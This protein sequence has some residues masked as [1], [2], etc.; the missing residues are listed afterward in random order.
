MRPRIPAS[1]PEHARILIIGDFPGA[2]DEIKGQIFQGTAGHELGKMLH[3]AGILRYDCRLTNIL[4]ARPSAG[5]LDEIFDFKKKKPIGTTIPLAIDELMKEIEQCN[6]NIII[7]LGGLALYA[8]NGDSAISTWRGS[9]LSL[10]GRKCIPTY[11]PSQIQRNWE[12]RAIAVADLRRAARE[13]SS[14]DFTPIVQNFIVRP[15]ASVVLTQLSSLLTRVQAQP[16]L[17]S[18]DI[19][20]RAGHTACTGIAWSK[21]DAICIPHMCVE[22]NDGFYDF[23]EEVAIILALRELLTHPNARVVGQNFLYDAQYFAKHWGFIPRLTEDTMFMQNMLFPGMPKGLDFL[24]SM[25]CENYTY[26][27]GEGKLW[28]P[29]LPEDQLWVYNCK[30][31]VNT[32]EIAE[33]C[34]PM[35]EQQNKTEQYRFQMALWWDVLDMMLRGVRIDLKYRQ[36]LSGEL[37]HEISKREEWLKSVCSHAL[38]PRSPKQMQA[39]FYADLRLPVQ[40]Q[41]KGTRSVTTDDEALE[42]LSVLEPL[43]A[44]ICNC[45]RELRS[46][47][48]FHSTF[49]LAGLGEDLRMRCSFN[50]AGT[51]TYRFNSSKD[52]FDSGTNLQNIPKGNEDEAHVATQLVL[53]NIRKLFIPDSEHIIFDVDLAG[54]DAQVVAWEANDDIL[55]SIFRS[56]QKVHAVNAKDIFGGNAGDDGKREPYYSR[57]K[58][59]CHLTNYGGK[60]RTLSIALGITI[61]E[62]ELFQRRWF[63][64]HPGIA[65]WHERVLSSLQTTRSISNK[66][67]YSRF[68]FDRIDGILPQALAWIPQSTVACVTNRQLHA[69]A[70]H[71]P[72]AQILLQVHDSLVG[73][74]HRSK[75]FLT[76]P[77]LR[78]RLRITVPYEDPL[79]IPSGLKT[80]QVSWGAAIDESWD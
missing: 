49:V 5:S 36:Q 46:L 55:K 73:Q 39:F 19:E 22:R 3:E 32:Y 9:L 11:H 58:A 14:P 16:T 68:Y 30:D 79:I 80:S 65:D 74:V 29:R 67:G 20:T 64:I 75:W 35:I 37:M 18:V 8:I 44:P 15:S 2:D 69:V 54:A 4:K 27:K 12:W 34:L 63:D 59:G 72:D 61:H 33:A 78:E 43:V 51:E 42:K 47:G 62:A 45:I 60:P 31:A 41:R 17:L 50:P 6:P 25:Y 10:N 57:A 53:P 38:N 76:K 23:E 52:A 71:I 7:A 24:A 77:L 40:R 70:I 48:V 1:G 26:W 28:D 56:G 21:T 66:F 13:S